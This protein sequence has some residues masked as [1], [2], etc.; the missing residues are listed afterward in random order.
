MSETGL[1]RRALIGGGIATGAALLAP[2]ALRDPAP[3]AFAPLPAEPVRQAVAGPELRLAFRCTHTGL[4]SDACFRRGDSFDR[5]GLAELDHALRD[6]RTGQA[7]EMDRGLLDLLVRLRDRL[8]VAPGTP[9]DLISAYRSPHTNDA[10]RGRSGGVASKSQHVLG[11]AVDIALPGISTHRIRDAALALRGGGVGH[12]PADGF[13]H[14]DT[15][16]VRFW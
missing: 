15:G 9:F 6:W 3:P 16:R 7:T 11:K 1:S 10:L 13:V 4:T 14:I 5:Q 12:Y 2:V 8:D